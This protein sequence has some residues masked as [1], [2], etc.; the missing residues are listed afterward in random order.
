MKSFLP[1]LL[2]LAAC[3][4]VPARE[5]EDPALL[6]DLMGRDDARLRE[7]GAYRLALAGAALPGVLE[8]RERARALAESDTASIRDRVGTA[9]KETHP[10]RQVWLAWH[11]LRLGCLARDW[12]RVF[13]ALTRQG[14]RLIEIYEPNDRV[15]FVRLLIQPGAYVNAARDRHDL[16]CWVQ[17]AKAD[18]RWRV[19][20]VYAGLYVRFD[21]AFKVLAATPRYGRNDLLQQFLDLPDLQ[22]IAAVYPN[23]E[24]LEFTY[25]RIRDRD[26]AGAPAGFHVN[27]GFVMDGKAGGRSVYYTAEAGL[28]PRELDRGRLDWAEFTPTADVGPLQPRGSGI[29]GSGGLRPVEDD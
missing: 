15:K 24:E 11:A 19:R 2:L 12:S 4:G 9:L 7:E 23:V 3:A 26:V 13:D 14:C 18:G 16:F 29:W 17:S 1:V 10:E 5:P 21:L 6:L 8:G 22:K 27:A 20:E 25:G 28:D